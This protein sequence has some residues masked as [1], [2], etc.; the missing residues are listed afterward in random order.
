VG[1]SAGGA[2]PTS[3]IPAHVVEGFRAVP[4]ATI[5]H[6]RQSGFVDP[7]IRPVY[8]FTEVVVGRA[9]TLKLEPGDVTHTRA[10]IA[11]LGTGDVLVVDQGGE[12]RTACWGEMTS[13]AAKM[14]GAAGVVID[15]ACTDVLEI[16]AMG[17]PT[18]ARGV[19][20]L[21]GRRLGRAGGPNVEVR[22]GGA[23]VRPGDLVVGDANGIV[24]IPPHE[25]EAVYR[26]A[27]EYEDRAPYQRRWLL[28]GGS[29]AE[30]SGL[31]AAQLAAKVGRREG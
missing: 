9:V 3:G 17:L 16:E 10:A 30:V 11:A 21:V 4:P 23:V 14:R 6:V 7:S 28:A 18:Y 5:G 27:R 19:A 29:L 22:C 26:E 31:T 15:G 24:V 25:A 13:L 1:G 12:C 8:R 2:P 20:A